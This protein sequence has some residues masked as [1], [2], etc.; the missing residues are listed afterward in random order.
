LLVHG[1]P[2][3]AS[4]VITH[5]PLIFCVLCLRRKRKVGSP[6]VDSMHLSSI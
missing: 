1:E 3:G 5:I 4:L 6:L 2:S